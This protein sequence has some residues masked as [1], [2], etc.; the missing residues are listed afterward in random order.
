MIIT[1]SRQLFIEYS[2]KAVT[3]QNVNSLAPIPHAKFIS[4]LLFIKEKTINLN[5]YLN[6]KNNRYP[7]DESDYEEDDSDQDEEDKKSDESSTSDSSDNDY[8]AKKKSNSPTNSS[9]STRSSCASGKPD[10][11]SKTSPT[12]LKRHVYKIRSKYESKGDETLT[13]KRKFLEKVKTNYDEEDDADDRDTTLNY[14]RKQSELQKGGDKSQLNFSNSMLYK[15]AAKKA[16]FTSSNPS[17]NTASNAIKKKLVTSVLSIASSPSVSSSS[18]PSSSSS[19][20]SSS[21]S[22][23][24][25][26]SSDKRAS[27]KSKKNAASSSTKLPNV[28][29]LK[30]STSS[31]VG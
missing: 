28:E 17:P 9:R 10:K 30:I 23:V 14:S 24:S 2:V 27:L 21:R 20:V 19:S 8:S 25:Q 15:D 29:N 5:V 11:K 16:S 13:E 12:L 18:S 1:I 4:V 26:S 7:N 31:R 6:K 22:S 3:F